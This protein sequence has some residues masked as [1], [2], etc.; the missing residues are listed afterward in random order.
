MHFYASSLD[1]KQIYLFKFRLLRIQ[2]ADIFPGVK[3]LSMYWSWSQLTGSRGLAMLMFAY[4]SPPEE[5]SLAVSRVP[6]RINAISSFDSENI[7]T[8]HTTHN[9]NNINKKSLLY[10]QSLSQW[11]SALDHRPHHMLSLADVNYL[12]N[13]SSRVGFNVPPNTLSGTILTGQ[14]TQPTVSSSTEG[15]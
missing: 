10:Y 4:S 9:T 14:M 5:R 13:R 3:C 1:T 11:R 15:H 7:W 6:N 12:L 8:K 2:S